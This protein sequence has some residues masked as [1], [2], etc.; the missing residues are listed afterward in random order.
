MELRHE[1]SEFVLDVVNLIA[2]F[3][4]FGFTLSFGEAWRNREVQ[5]YYVKTGKSKTLK[6]THLD[7][8]GIDFNIFKDGRQLFAKGSTKEQYEADL[9]LVAPVGKYWMELSPKNVWGAD[10][11]R[12]FNLLEH[13]FSD[14]YHWE[15]KI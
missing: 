10:W 13:S 2:Y 7:R 5:E 11:D 4:S 9:K 15:R 14:P 8:L 6:S 12:D 1:Q 3:Y